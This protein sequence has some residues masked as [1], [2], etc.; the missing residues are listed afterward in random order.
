MHI[1]AEL[2]IREAE[3]RNIND[4]GMHDER[5]FDF[6]RVDVDAAGNNC[7]RSAVS[8]VEK[9]V[10][11]EI[12]DVTKRHPVVKLRMATVFRLFRISVVFEI[13][14][15]L[16]EI[17]KANS[18]SF[19]FLAFVIANMR[20]AINRLTDRTRM[21]QP[22]LRCKE[23][24]AIA[25]G[26]GVVLAHDRAK[27]LD[28]LPFGLGRTRRCGVHHQLKA[29]QVVTSLD[30]IGQSQHSH[31][32]RGNNLRVSDRIAFD[33]TQKFLCIELLENDNGAT[34]FVNTTGPNDCGRVIQRGRT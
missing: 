8:E 12:A 10:L 3:H 32:H 23:C 26:A 15:G 2:R 17:H 30:L 19:E 28:H 24:H 11:V 34:E 33:N 31:H 27:P 9:A 21:C 25:F 22:L 6:G 16:F 5:R 1:L 13:G 4:I 14:L 7:E 20:N 29:R 18:T